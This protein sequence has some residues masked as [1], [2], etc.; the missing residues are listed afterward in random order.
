MN[1]NLA[2]MKYEEVAKDADALSSQT[3]GIAEKL[4]NPLAK[5]LTMRVSTLASEVRNAAVKQGGDT[6]KMK[7]AEIKATCGECH[8]KI[9]DKK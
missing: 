2:E 6:V 9:R 3:A 1:A 7:L 5:E 8:A 4:G